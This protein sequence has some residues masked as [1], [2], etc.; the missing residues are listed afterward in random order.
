LGRARPTRVCESAHARAR[1]CTSACE[2]R[3]QGHGGGPERR[4]RYGNRVKT[5]T[6]KGTERAAAPARK[7]SQHGTKAGLTQRRARRRSGRHGVPARLEGR[8]LDGEW[9]SASSPRWPQAEVQA[10]VQRGEAGSSTR[11]NTAARSRGSR[12]R[13]CDS[14]GRSLLLG[15][16]PVFA[17]KGSSSHGRP[18][19]LLPLLLSPTST[20]AEMWR[21]SPVRLGLGLCASGSYL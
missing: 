6:R 11:K 9:E 7:I 17:A 20:A 5:N 8:D 12:A 14:P 18:P 13:R 16:P 2:R 15:R 4:R 3:C 19:R 10:S 21:N 1:E